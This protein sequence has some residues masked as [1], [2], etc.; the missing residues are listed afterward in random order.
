VTDSALAGREALGRH[1][2]DEALEAFTE[3]DRHGDLSPDDLQLLAQAAWWSGRPDDAVAAWERAFAGHSAAGD[4]TAAAG[5]ALRLAEL[6]FRRNA[7]SIAGGWVARAERMLEDEPESA[8][9]AW[10][11]FLRSA[12]ALYRVKDWE[13]A[14][15]HADRAIAL[16]MEHGNPDVQSISLAF[17]GQALLRQGKCK[18]G[19]VL[20]DEATAGAVSGELDPKTA[21][22]VYCVTIAGCRTLADYRRAGEWTEEADRWMQR[23]A[24]RGYRGACRL[25][26]AELKRLHGDWAEAEQ[27]VRS[28]CRELEDFRLLDIVG[29]AHYELGEV[30]LHMGDLVAAEEAFER[31]FEYGRDPQPGMA[32]LLLARGDVDGAAASIERSLTADAAPMERG[33]APSPDLLVRAGILPAMVEIALARRDIATARAAV[34]ELGEIVVAYDIPALQAASLTARGALQ[35][36]EG[37]ASEAVAT[38][39]RAWRLWQEIDLPYEGA[40]AR[41]LLGEAR[42]AAGDAHTARMEIRAARAVFERLG[43][44]LDL[45]R[46]GEILDEDE[47]VPGAADGRAVTMTF[48]FTDIVTSTDLLGLIGDD[49]WGSLLRWHDRELRSAFS[50]H[51]GEEAKHTGDGFFVAFERAVDAVECAVDIQRRLVAHR[52][53]HGFAPWVRI[54]LHTAEA[55]RRGRDYT[56]RGVNVAARVCDLADREEIVA[57]RDVLDAAS[58]MRFRTSGAHAAAL[59]GV[60]EPVEVVTVDWR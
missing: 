32:L 33:E 25:H 48:M 34:E 52:Q 15:E 60:A 46:A 54:G 49:A 59:K 29:D 21:C 44:A 23:H 2:W 53:E 39:S 38:L 47:A 42:Q 27:E 5:A 20:F 22:D 10:L 51:G 1:A 50:Q 43:A 36:A 26:R 3:A 13:A 45:R 6:A 58:S 41:L 12:D 37:Q 30:R 19:L 18:E 7:Y 40:R 57:T 14:I 35:V 11:E 24:I 55:T 8:V 16:G 9:H 28:A 56:G 17:K 31:A 4:S